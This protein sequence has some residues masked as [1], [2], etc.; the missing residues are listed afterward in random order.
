MVQIHFIYSENCK[1]CQ[2]AL[3]TIESA[4]KKCKNIPC[5]IKKY[6]YNNPIAISIA[7]NNNINDLP[8]FV[9]GNTVFMGDDYD[10]KKIIKAIEDKDMNR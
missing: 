10:E 7:I 3:A 4:I 9:V 5:E 8:G 1:H 2:Q 6:I